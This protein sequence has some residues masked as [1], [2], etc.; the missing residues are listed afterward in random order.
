[1]AL[2]VDDPDAPDPAA[3][4]MT[5]VHWVLYDIPPGTT[6]LP[7]AVSRL[8]AGALEGLND[9]GETGYTGPCPPIGRH[10]YFH[11]LYALDTVLPDLGLPTK[12]KLEAAMKGHVVAQAELIGTYQKRR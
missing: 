1:L 2:I 8:P 5:F 10:R 4:K 12:A 3:P 6:S 11:K 9:A 7:E